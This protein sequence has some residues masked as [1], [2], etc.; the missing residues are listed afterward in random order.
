VRSYIR[1]KS[2][3]NTSIV[4][5]SGWK[6]FPHLD[7]NGKDTVHLPSATNNYLEL[8]R[9]ARDHGDVVCFNT[10]GWIKKEL[11]PRKEW[12]RLPQFENPIQGL[13]VKSS[14]LEKLDNNEKT[15]S[16]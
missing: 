14:E 2:N 10:D 1:E 8:F 4:L 9:Y 3:S 13:F 12:N 16:Q 7:S 15:G 5:P 6:F 11:R